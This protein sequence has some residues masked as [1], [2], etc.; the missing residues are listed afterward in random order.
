MALQHSVPSMV[1]PTTAAQT[2]SDAKKPAANNL[3]TTISK[4]NL[5][6]IAGGYNRGEKLKEKT[7]NKNKPKEPYKAKLWPQDFQTVVSGFVSLFKRAKPSR[8]D[9]EASFSLL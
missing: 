6:I 8:A 5:A 1:H 7:I 4:K 9:Q 3:N 2:K